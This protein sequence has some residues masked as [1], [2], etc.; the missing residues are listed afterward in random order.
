[1]KTILNKPK[2]IA[3]CADVNQ[4]KSMFLYH[5]IHEARKEY[6]FNLYYYGLRLTVPNAQEVY[7]VQE[8][9]TIKN[10]I[11]VI[12]EL[13][14]LFDL[15]DRKVK[16]Q[17]ENTLRLINHNNN[18]L[19]ICGPPENFKKFLSGKINI[20]FFKRCTIADFIN[21][22]KIKNVL[23][24]YRG[25]ERGAEVLNMPIDQVLF[26]DGKHYSKM[27]VPYRKQYD[28]KAENKDILQKCTEKRPKK[29]S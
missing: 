12:D 21:G 9:E 27:H 7:T 13:S 28:T 6:N 1:M 11:I 15:D 14:S 4:G 2:V 19:I 18:I 26:Y 17:I 3:V 25:N 22:S 8:I 5:L 10:S 20:V 29:R 24:A 16:K 23:T